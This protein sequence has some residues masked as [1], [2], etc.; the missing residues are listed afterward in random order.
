[1]HNLLFEYQLQ[2]EDADLRTYANRLQ[3]DLARYASETTGHVHLKKIREDIQGGGD[4]GARATPAFFINNKIK[5]V[6]FGMHS[7]FDA[8]AAAMNSPKLP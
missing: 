2:L 1:M 8:V 3:L 7:L 6:S 5:D 4:S